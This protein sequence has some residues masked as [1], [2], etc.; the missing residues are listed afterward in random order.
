[1]TNPPFD[2]PAVRACA[3]AARER[4]GRALVGAGWWTLGAIALWVLSQ[5]ATGWVM[6]RIAPLPDP[7]QVAQA[8]DIATPLALLV[9]VAVRLAGVG[10]QL[11]V[12]CALPLPALYGMAWM[13]VRASRG[14]PVAVH[15]MRG[16]MRHAS[17]FAGVVALLALAV[18]V[19]FMLWALAIV[20]AGVVITVQAMS[21]GVEGLELTIRVWWT[22]V[23][24]AVPFVL[25]S[26][27]IQCRWIYAPLA[28]ADG[29]GA[30]EAMRMS[31]RITRSG[32]AM[33]WTRIAGAM[34]GWAVACTAMLVLP[35]AWIGLPR[36]AACFAAGYV[37]GR[38]AAQSVH[39]GST[40][41]S[42]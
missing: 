23:A 16:P 30:W 2:W 19:P 28:V 25:A 22:S 7:E 38:D 18:V 9:T 10:V 14:E 5:L 39:A 33:V 29:A 36:V 13:C 15:D 41:G 20:I 3:E 31:W 1:M 37:R 26:V 24:L 4:A 11:A 6:D 17:S 42:Q 40:H 32:R 21:E 27:W 35:L 12:F 8:Q 34:L